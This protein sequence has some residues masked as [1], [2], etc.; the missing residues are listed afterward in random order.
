MA[1]SEYDLKRRIKSLAEG[2]N[3]SIELGFIK[4]V[5]PFTIKIG[6]AEYSTDDNAWTFY[7]PIYNEKNIKSKKVTLTAVKCYKDGYISDYDKIEAETM[8][9]EEI[10]SEI[11]YNAGDM[12]AVEQMPGARSFIILGKLRRL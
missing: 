5:E 12:V 1:Y 7:E 4:S 11:K 2:V 3:T 8:Q 10:E 9:A 6:D